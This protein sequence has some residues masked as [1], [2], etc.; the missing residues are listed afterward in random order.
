M[1]EHVDHAQQL[2]RVV[3]IEIA[4]QDSGIVHGD[5]IRLLAT[6]QHRARDG[7]TLPIHALH[8]VV[9]DG[10]RV[11][12]A[13]IQLTVFADE[14][15]DLA[16]LLR[17]FTVV[18][19]ALGQLRQLLLSGDGLCHF[20]ERKQDDI[21]AFPKMMSQAHRIPAGGDKFQTLAVNRLKHDGCRRRAIAAVFIKLPEHLAQQHCAHI[22]NGIGQVG[23]A[24][25]DQAAFV[26]QLRRFV[27]QRL[28][29]GDGAG[30]GTERRADRI[31]DQIDAALQAKGSIRLKDQAFW[32]RRGIRCQPRIAPCVSPAMICRCIKMKMMRMGKVA[33]NDPAMIAPVSTS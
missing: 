19:N 21:K 11:A 16:Q 32:W 17:Q 29:D 1:H 22:G 27:L 12:A 24:P 25:G 15:E 33:R 3:D 26:Q 5:A 23:D 4:E 6:T 13:D 14:V 28:T 18:A 30:D 8:V 20:V 2:F 9:L 31:D 10:T 7:A